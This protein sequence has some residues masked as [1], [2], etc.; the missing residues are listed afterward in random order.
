MEDTVTTA[1]EHSDTSLPAPHHIDE[2]KEATARKMSIERDLHIA[3]RIQ[4]G[5]LPKFFPTRD[6]RDDVQIYASLTPAYV[7]HACRCHCYSLSKIAFFSSRSPYFS[8]HS[9]CQ[10]QPSYRGSASFSISISIIRS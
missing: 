4:R 5:M 8:F 3:S 7:Y 2:L 6:G 9:L 10:M 1:S